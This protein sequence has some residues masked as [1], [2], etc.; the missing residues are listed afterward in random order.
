MEKT[1]VVANKHIGEYADYWTA[2]EVTM[3]DE[4]ISQ[5]FPVEHRTIKSLSLCGT[6]INRNKDRIIT[7]IK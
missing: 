1:F 6:I 4:E 3:N 7:R 2:H 5:N